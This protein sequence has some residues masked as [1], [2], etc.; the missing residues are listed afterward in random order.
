MR[1]SK[2]PFDLYMKSNCV[3]V[4]VMV[5]VCG[6]VRVIVSVFVKGDFEKRNLFQ[7]V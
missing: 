7:F 3:C 1:F 4:F 6:L 5:I 2:G